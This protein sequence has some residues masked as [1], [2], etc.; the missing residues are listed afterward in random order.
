VVN[1]RSQKY[2]GS[3]QTLNTKKPVMEMKGLKYWIDCPNSFS[4]E[5]EAKRVNI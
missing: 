2:A 5:R 4:T 1:S 3:P